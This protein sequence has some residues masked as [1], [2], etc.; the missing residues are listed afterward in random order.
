MN[1]QLSQM[2]EEAKADTNSTSLTAQHVADYQNRVLRLEKRIDD[3]GRAQY[4]AKLTAPQIRIMQENARVLAEKFKDIK[5]TTIPAWQ[6]TFSMYLVQLEQQKGAQLATAIHDATDDAF[7]LQADLLRQNTAT[8]ATA[9]QRSI[10]SLE[11]VQHMQEQLLGAMDDMA[12]IND[13]GRK[14]RLEATPKFIALEQEL[15]NRFTPKG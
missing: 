2:I 14:S 7:K 13:E 1:T 9:K 10:V 15:I 12:R 11:T 6:N 8:I 5:V 3:L 4:L